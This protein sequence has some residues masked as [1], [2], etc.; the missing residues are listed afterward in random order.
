MKWIEKTVLLA[1]LSVMILSATL[2]GIWEDKEML[3]PLPVIGLYLV[4]ATWAVSRCRSG[5]AVKRGAEDGRQRTE[6]RGQ[7]AG[8]RR[9]EIRSQSSPLTTQHHNN[10]T[11]EPAKPEIR[12]Q[13]ASDEKVRNKDNSGFQFPVSSF[14][15]PL[16]G[17]FLLFFW[18]YSAALIPFSVLP[19]EA[20]IS[21]LRFGCYVGA[22][23]AAANILSR[24]PVRKAFWMTLFIALVFIA[25]YSLVQHKV[26]PNE[27]FGMERYTKYWETGRAGGTYQCPN[28]IAHL[29]QMWVPLCLVFLF[30]PQFSWFARIFFAYGIPLFLI[31]IYQ[32]QS[33]AGL[34]GV[35]AGL[36]VTVLMLI[37]RKS[38][39]WF[40]IALLVVPLLGAGAIGGLWAGS[41]MFRTRMMP[42]V[43]FFQHQMQEDLVDEQFKDFRPQTWLDTIDM[44]KDRP[45]F[46]FGPGNY[47]LL[48]ENYRFRYIGR[49]I[50]TVHPHNEYL[51]LLAEYGLVGGVL[52]LGVLL[53]VCIPLIRLIRTSSRAYHA[54]PAA[55]FIGALAGTAV[56]GFFD[57]ELRIFPNALMLALLAGCAVAPLVQSNIERESGGRRTED[58]GRKTE[59]GR[60][61]IR[62]KTGDG[63]GRKNRIV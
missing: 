23:W 20:V 3:F 24:L 30:L 12:E 41:E 32:T 56:H 5:G 54:L 35:I 22:Y 62:R 15:P 63:N 40:F 53:S 45:V 25:L 18:L 37:W 7:G 43:K 16:G 27:L 46:G 39:R 33:R 11:T 58:R 52:V 50:E 28:H 42:V 47:G 6:D 17:V 36:G 31:L 10:M 60:Q 49:R 38:R 4:L 19:Y 9:T 29:F 61:G 55:A 14:Q 21:T 8:G 57:F 44:I 1:L 59:D 2:Y 51:E 48:F 13:K 26:A 34:L